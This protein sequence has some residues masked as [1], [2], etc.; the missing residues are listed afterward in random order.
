MNKPPRSPYLSVEHTRPE[1][2]SNNVTDEAELVEGYPHT[3][4]INAVLNEDNTPVSSSASSAAASATS[5]SPTVQDKLVEYLHNRGGKDTFVS[6]G[7]LDFIKE[8][9][10]SA[11][12]AEPKIKLLTIL[13]NLQ[14]DRFEVFE[15]VPYSG[16]YSCRLI[17]NS[18]SSSGAGGRRGGRRHTKRSGRSRRK[19]T[20]R[21][22]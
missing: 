6:I 11:R 19:N 5:G 7:K 21:R 8:A 20:R 1:K 18:S 13:R 15:Q 12:V 2:S 17:T 4:S 22:L 3:S 16:V 9:L 14:D 10:A